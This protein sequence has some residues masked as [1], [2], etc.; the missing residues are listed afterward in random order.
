MDRYTAKGQVLDCRKDGQMNLKWIGTIVIVMACGSF[1]FKLAASNH[2]QVRELRELQSILDLMTC[3]LRYRLTPLPEL[4][5]IAASS[6]KGNVSKLFRTLHSELDGQI[7]P[8]A[9]C[10]MNAAVAHSS[11]TQTTMQYL[12]DL[13]RSLGRFDL[14]GQLQEI[15]AIKENIAQVL[16]KLTK[17]QDVRLRSYQT[18]GLCVGAALAILL[19]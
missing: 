18:L 7:S 9:C 13:G 17:D 5:L 1:G 14:D 6:S 19:L 16:D 10:C 8:D 11:L 15:Q 12:R 4:C 3:E 2:Q